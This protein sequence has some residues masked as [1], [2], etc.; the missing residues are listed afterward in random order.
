M[1]YLVWIEISLMCYIRSYQ[2][3]TFSLCRWWTGWLQIGSFG[4]I[5]RIVSI[6]SNR[7]DLLKLAVAGPMAGFLLGF[8][9][10]LLGFI[11]PP[12][13]GIG[14]VIDSAIFHES[15]LAG[16]VGKQLYLLK[17]ISLHCK[18]LCLFIFPWDCQLIMQMVVFLFI[19][20]K[21]KFFLT[22]AKLLLGD[23]LKEGARLSVNPLVLW[24]WAGLLINAINSIP[25]GELDGGRISFA[26]WG[27]KVPFYSC[28]WV[29][30]HLNVAVVLEILLYTR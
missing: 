10:F 12:N 9:L 14:I 23:A 11:L 5:T 4:A 24:A 18:Q 27:R 3:L 8:T 29:L 30:R 15:F 28:M 26:L 20:C 19:T 1:T 25:A 2:L 7:Q 22:A 13:D 21:M 6:V 17:F 16:G